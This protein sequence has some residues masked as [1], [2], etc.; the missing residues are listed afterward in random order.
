MVCEEICALGGVLGYV[1]LIWWNNELSGTWYCLYSECTSCC[2]CV[3]I[4]VQ[5]YPLGVM[6]N[7]GG[8]IWLLDTAVILDVLEDPLGVMGNIGGDIRSSKVWSS[9]VVYV[10][11]DPFGVEGDIGGDIWL[12]DTAVILDVLEDPLGVKADAKSGTTV[13]LAPLSKTKSSGGRE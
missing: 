3:C 6:S 5:L 12:L 13:G 4:I 9:I 1:A 8:D 2:N 7:I 11:E 10:L